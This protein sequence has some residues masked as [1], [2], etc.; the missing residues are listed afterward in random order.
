M[1]LTAANVRAIFE[2]CLSTS[3]DESTTIGKGIGKNVHF[4]SKKLAERRDKIQN[5]LTQL[6][7]YFKQG[8]S[9]L[10]ACMTNDGEQ[11]GE[12][13]DVE[14]LVHLATASELMTIPFDR[15]KWEHLP[16]GMP[17]LIYDETC[18]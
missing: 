7:S 18:P 15:E 3:N 4:S 6:P 8:A 12:H 13:K 17:Y 11:W 9:F 16:G 1:N 5:M 10:N 14:R 2:Y